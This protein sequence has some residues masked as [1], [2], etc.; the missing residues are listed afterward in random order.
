MLELF[1]RPLSEIPIKTVSK[2]RQKPFIELVDQ[3]LSLTKDA[4]YLCNN[5]KQFK[6][7]ALEKRIDQ[8]VYSLYELTPNES[9]FIDNFRKL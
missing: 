4:H 3:I 8:L 1:Y 7:N 9:A 2:D 6:V 5:E